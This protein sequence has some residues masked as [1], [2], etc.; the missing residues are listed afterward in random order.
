ME[1]REDSSKQRGRESLFSF[2]CSGMVG[3]VVGGIFSQVE[4]EIFRSSLKNDMH[5]HV[6]NFRIDIQSGAR[7]R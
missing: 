1:M 4:F 6:I 5:S 2:N 7:F 3:C